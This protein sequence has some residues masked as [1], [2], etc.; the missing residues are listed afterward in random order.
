MCIGYGL[1]L[2]EEIEDARLNDV[3]RCL[4]GLVAKRHRFRKRVVAWHIVMGY[5]WILFRP[6]FDSLI[7]ARRFI[8]KL[9]RKRNSAGS[10]DYIGRQTHSRMHGIFNG[11]TGIPAADFWNQ[12]WVTGSLHASII[13][14]ISVRAFLFSRSVRSVAHTATLINF[15][16]LRF[17]SRSREP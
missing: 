1:Y 11:P 5:L 16:L 8:G 9:T 4:T 2:H 10:H 12:P 14:A 15:N 7:A 3:C 6:L 13:A 17:L